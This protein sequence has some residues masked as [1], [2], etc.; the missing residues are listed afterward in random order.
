MTTWNQ[1]SNQTAEPWS[2]WQFVVRWHHCCRLSVFVIYGWNELLQTVHWKGS[3]RLVT[4]SGYCSCC[5]LLL[6]AS[7]QHGF[8]LA[9]AAT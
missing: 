2:L 8:V 5:S 3:V 6:L 9:L 4:F 7:M 1:H